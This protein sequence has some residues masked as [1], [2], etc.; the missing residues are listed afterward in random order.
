MGTSTYKPNRAC[1]NYANCKRTRK[2]GEIFCHTCYFRLPKEK[3]DLL[4]AR[5]LHALAPAIRDCL[6][7]LNP[8]EQK[9]S[10]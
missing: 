7:Y 8:A 6:A 1:P 10:K 2:L 5:N 3:R 9:E 4:W